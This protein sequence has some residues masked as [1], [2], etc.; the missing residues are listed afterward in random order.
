M[1]HTLI[2]F[3][4]DKLCEVDF[5]C[6]Y[7]IIQTVFI[8]RYKV[9]FP[10]WRWW[11]PLQNFAI[12]SLDDPPFK[13]RQE[14]EIS[15]SAERPDWLWRP[16]D[17]LCTGYR[18]CPHYVFIVCTGAILPFFFF[19]IVS[20]E[21]L[22]YTYGKLTVIFFFASQNFNI[23]IK[24]TRVSLLNKVLAVSSCTGPFLYQCAMHCIR[25][26]FQWCVFYIYYFLS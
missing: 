23:T 13:S 12:C 24:L 14:H 2:L 15:C 7:I 22:H 4:A 26:L 8:I 17:L 1:M 21:R 16:P 6:V 5:N 9:N 25:P 11:P 3:C 18:R 20:L 19:K 10:L